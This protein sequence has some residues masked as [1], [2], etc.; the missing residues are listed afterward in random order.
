MNEY[1]LLVDQTKAQRRII[2]QLIVVLPIEIII[3]TFATIFLINNE[4]IAGLFALLVLVI[5]LLWSIAAFYSMVTIPSIMNLIINDRGI[6]F[7]SKERIIRRYEWSDI[8]NITFSSEVITGDKYQI[9]YMEIR[10]RSGKKDRISSSVVGK[11]NLDDIS[12]IVL[13]HSN[14]LGIQVNDKMN[15]RDHLISTRKFVEKQ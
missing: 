7:S 1:S 15:I 3:A 6:M 5:F 11:K 14:P 8:E 10:I 12:M 13:D 4:I 2:V 9:Y